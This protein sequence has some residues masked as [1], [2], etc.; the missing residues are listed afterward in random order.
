MSQSARIQQLDLNLLKIFHTLY[1][2]QNMT[3]TAEALHLTPSAVS[4]AVKRLRDTLGDPLFKRSQNKMLPTPAC[5]RM[6]PLIIDNLTRLQQ[7][8]Q[9][10]GHFEPSTSEHHFTIGMHDAYEQTIIPQLS[11]LFAQHAPNVSFSSVKVERSNVAR[12]LATGHVDMVIDVSIPVPADVQRKRLS[13][14]NFV[15]LLR[16]DH[17]ML[18]NLDQ[19]HYLS[20]RH[21]IVSNRPSGMTAEDMLFQQQGIVRNISIRCQNYFAAK[22]VAKNSDQLLTLPRSLASQLIDSDI[23]VR[24]VPIE[25]PNFNTDLYWH[26]QTENDAALIWLRDLFKPALFNC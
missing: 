6:A 18:D 16:T 8:L 12:N 21:L 13:S 3:R 1:V 15:V 19:A 14:S 22:E 17:P 11:K 20:A 26:R 24:P 23:A 25:L 2:E 7:I 10:W 5:Q 9:Q 4:H